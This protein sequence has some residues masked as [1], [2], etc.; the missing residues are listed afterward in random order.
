M[1]KQYDNNNRGVLFRNKD[2]ETETHP[3]YKG[4]INVGGQEFWLSAWLRDSD[5]AGKYMSLSIQPR[6]RPDVSKTVDKKTRAAE[7]RHDDD[8]GGDIPF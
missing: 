3:D 2:K 5:K 4:N 6:Q 8:D 1:S 7:P